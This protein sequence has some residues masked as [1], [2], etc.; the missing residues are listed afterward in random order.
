[1]W[2]E[3]SHKGHFRMQSKFL[4]R[5]PILLAIAMWAIFGH[6]AQASVIDEAVFNGVRYYLISPGSWHDSESQAQAMGGHLAVIEDMEEQEFIYSRFGSAALAASPASGKVN[7]W[8]GLTDQ[9]MDGEFEATNGSEVAF[10]YFFTNQPQ[11]NHTDE[12][13]MG[14]RV[15]GWNDSFPV[16]KWIDI[17]SNTRLGDLSY[18]VVKV[19]VAVPEPAAW[20]LALTGAFC[21]W[22]A[23]ACKRSTFA[24]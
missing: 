18:G 3:S 1:M 9:D 13:F 4:T 7:L 21:L 12:M 19:P 24:A 8:L 11:R 23:A 2:R 17:V 10:E 15:R 6:A 22:R 14:I 5:S 20:V 16:G